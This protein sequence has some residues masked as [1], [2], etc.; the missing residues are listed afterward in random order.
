TFPYSSTKA[1]KK[2]VEALQAQGHRPTLSRLNDSFAV[3]VRQAGYPEQCIFENSE[4]DA[5]A[6][7][8]RLES[9]RHRGLFI[10]YGK[11]RRVTFADLLARY[12]REEAPRHKGF[13]V[14][15]YIIN[16]ILEDAGLP[17][18]DV[19]QAYAEH[20]NPHPK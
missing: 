1:V 6:T 2:Y 10:D 18:V 14:E 19:A 5:I 12:L 20:K 17:R 7:Q 9:E 8:Q 13:L 3:R 11:A 4:E 16:G 15:G